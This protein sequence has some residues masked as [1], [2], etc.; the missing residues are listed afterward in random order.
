MSRGERMCTGSDE[1][2][3]RHASG[4]TDTSDS[5]VMWHRESVSFYGRARSA[6][7]HA[8]A[9]NRE[10]DDDDDDD[11]E[12]CVGQR[13][14]ECWYREVRETERQRGTSRT[15]HTL[16]RLYESNL[17][18]LACAP[19]RAHC[20]AGFGPPRIHHAD[21]LAATIKTGMQWR[22]KAR[23]RRRTYLSMALQM[24]GGL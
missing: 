24:T 10:R 22:A 6:R 13:S 9:R 4:P 11:D 17:V 20:N 2:Q 14:C 16:L 15:A 8:R 12:A 5:E 7:A 3:P 23:H 19:P 1:D 18:Q 21:R